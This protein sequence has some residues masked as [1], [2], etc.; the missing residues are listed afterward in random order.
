MV[1]IPLHVTPAE[2]RVSGYGQNP[3]LQRGASEIMPR[4]SEISQT[5]VRSERQ[6]STSCIGFG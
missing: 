5:Q 2:M 3:T 6:D 1:Y 4:R